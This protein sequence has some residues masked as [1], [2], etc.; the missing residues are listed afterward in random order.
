MKFSVDGKAFQQQL[1]AVSRV[2]NAK[3]ALS[4]LDNFLLKIEGDSLSITGSDQENTLT[5]TLAVTESDGNGIIAMPARRLLDII[6]EIS[7]QPLTFN[8][9][10]DTKEVDLMFLNGHFNFMGIAGEDY[11]QDRKPGEMRTMI[12][13]AS[14]VLK[15][16]ENTMYAAS[17]DTVRPVMTGIFW[18]IHEEDITFVSSDTHKLVRYINQEKAPGLT[19]SFIFPP[20][21]AQ[22]LR[23]LLNK[24]TADISI[25]FDEKGCRMEFG[26]FVLSSLFI[27]GNYPNYAR[28]IPSDSPFVLMVDRLSLLTA[29]R[30]ITLF[31]SK[32][33]NLVVLN[34]QPD[35]IL[36]HAQDLDYGQSAEERVSCSYEGNEMIVG[37]NGAFMIDILSNM[38]GDTILLKLSDPARPGVYVPF[39]QQEGEDILV[40]QMPMQ[41]I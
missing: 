14:M 6:K 15:G 26:D 36:L 18:D 7:N 31:A 21:P 4:I 28:V 13:P 25:S 5:A 29:L 2:I 34:L 20:K 24:D 41:V 12:L 3:N 1:Q 39:Q 37:F 38:K 16:I 19:A 8:I 10:E 40:I 9:N 32:A 35:E 17:M 11:P 33:S 23:N 30:R 27:N 22:V